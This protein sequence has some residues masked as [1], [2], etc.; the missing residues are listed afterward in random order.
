MQPGPFLDLPVPASVRDVC[1]RATS[2]FVVC[3]VAA[4]A[5][6]TGDIAAC[7]EVRATAFALTRAAVVAA[8]GAAAA[9]AVFVVPPACSASPRCQPAPSSAELLTL[10]D[11]EPDLT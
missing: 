4:V 5:C 8:S 9:A 6:P 10:P 1:L 3:C 2:G 7:W 11:T